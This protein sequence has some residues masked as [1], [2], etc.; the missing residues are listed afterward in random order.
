MGI[1]LV[2]MEDVWI[3]PAIPFAVFILL[4][5]PTSVPQEVIRHQ[6]V[7]FPEVYRGVRPILRRAVGSDNYLPLVKQAERFDPRIVE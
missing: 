5:T 1:D 7:R 4:R 2:G 6:T 3:L